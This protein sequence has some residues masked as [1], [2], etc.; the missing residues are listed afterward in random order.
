MNFR[1]ILFLIFFTL[2][3]GFYS[4]TVAQNTPAKLV[5]NK[6]YLNHCIKLINSSQHTINICH[7]YFQNDTTTEKIKNALLDALNRKVEINIL[8]EDSIDDN[9]KMVNTFR[10]MGVDAKLDKKKSTLHCKFIVSD[11][12]SVLI[13]STNLSA[14]SIN[15]NNE[16]NV[17]I[18]DKG[19]T[20]SFNDYFTDIWH[21]KKYHLKHLTL[22]NYVNHLFDK[23]LFEALKEEITYAKKNISI[24][25]YYAAYYPDYPD[26]H[27][28]QLYEMLIKAKNRGVN[29]RIILE[30]SDHNDKLNFRNRKTAKYLI[31]NGIDIKF[32]SINKITH[33]K[34]II[35]DDKIILGSS[36]WGNKSLTENNEANVMIRDSELS[37]E[38]LEY[39]NDIWHLF[40]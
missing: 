10:Q 17:L 21:G 28:N 23:Y 13:G 19:V 31:K 32:D 12:K 39:F 15:N 22:D 25:M 5:L 24:L 4:T 30:L 16:A 8:L 37:K 3:S 34:F 7:L 2:F 27:S 35:V 18:N 29:V 33:S 38:L 14:N 9:M 26:S 11:N 36:N 6:A 20:A 40:N 1:R